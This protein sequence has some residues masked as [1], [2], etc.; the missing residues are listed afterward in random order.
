MG[1]VVDPSVED[2]QGK[3]FSAKSPSSNET[4]TTVGNE[5]ASSF[6]L[7]TKPSTTDSTSSTETATQNET[8]D[9]PKRTGHPVRDRLLAKAAQAGQRVSKAPAQTA[10]AG[11]PSSQVDRFSSLDNVSAELEALAHRAPDLTSP[12]RTA[13][14]ALSARSVSVFAVLI[15]IALVATLFTLLIQFAPKDETAVLVTTPQTVQQASTPEIRD[16]AVLPPPPLPKRKRKKGPWR[17]DVAGS[18]ERVLRGTVGKQAFLSAVQTAGLSKN[19]AYRVFNALKGSRNLDR[20][21]PRHEFA[22]LLDDSSGEVKAFEY[23]V[24]EEEVYQ[25]KENK[26]GKLDGK[27]L[28]LQVE[29]GRVQGAITV[30]STNF[31]DDA[32]R[33]KF[34]PTIGRVLDK[35][36]DGHTSVSHFSRGDRLRIVAQEVTVLGQFSR[37]A[38]IEAL[39]YVPATGKPLRIYYFSQ[40]RKYY[41]GK[42]RAPGEGGWRKPVRGPI[43]SKFNPKRLHPILKKRMPHNGTDF[44]APTG[45]PIYASSHGT[46]VTRGDYG[47][48]GNYIALS[49]SGGYHTGYSHLSR[50]EKGLKVGDKVKRLQVIG[51]VGTTGRSTG[52]HLHFSAKK[53]GAFIDPESLGLDALSSLPASQQAVFRKIKASYNSQLD[54]VKLP[55]ALAGATP[56]PTPARAPS[57]RT[58]L[59][60][61]SPVSLPVAVVPPQPATLPVSPVVRLPTASNAPEVAAKPSAPASLPAAAAAIPAAKRTFDSLY[62]SDKELIQAQSFLD[63]GEVEE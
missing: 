43:T 60:A 12:V 33:A 34:H 2:L 49:H 46:I 59:E 18:G 37:Y 28:D 30:T 16:D 62:L 58:N 25:A 39:E 53:N 7:T 26:Q 14:A 31:G 8:P 51:Y 24:S 50:F 40:R 35:A 27:R 29:K 48:N 10:R 19:Q 41:D 20:C 63:D 13:G 15:G 57:M 61:S 54:A 47:P 11:E 52:P 1:L 42:G 5:A 3:G 6:E 36:L 21:A 56:T 22:A 23:I 4:Q 9:P 17:V 44:G 32:K 45:T 55:P 38:G